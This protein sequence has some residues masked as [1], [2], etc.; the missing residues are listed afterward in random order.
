MIW[1]FMLYSEEGRAL[2]LIYTCAATGVIDIDFSPRPIDIY[3]D[4][5]TGSGSGTT[6]S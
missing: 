2:H 6:V 5:E 3:S 4:Y 1:T